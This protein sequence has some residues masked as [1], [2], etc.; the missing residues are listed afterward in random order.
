MN[1]MK[2]TFFMISIWSLSTCLEM[3]F[4]AEEHIKPVDVVVI[5]PTQ[6]IFTDK[7]PIQGNIIAKEFAILSARTPGALDNIFVDKGDSIK[8]GQILFETDKTNLENQV[9]AAEQNINVALASLEE[10]NATIEQCKANYQKT[11]RDFERFQSLYQSGVTTSDMKE[12]AELVFVQAKAMLKQAE[13]K[14]VLVEAKIQQA[15]TGLAICQKNRNDSQV[16]AAFNAVVS[17]RFREPGEF[18]GSGT[19]ILRLVNMDSLEISVALNAEYYGQIQVQKSKLLVE[20]GQTQAE[21]LV[22][23]RAPTVDPITRTFEIRAKIPHK[24]NKYELTEGMACNLQVILQTRQGWG[25]PSGAINIRSNQKVIYLNNQEVAQ[26][27]VVQTGII[28][29]GETEILF[30]KN[31]QN[32]EVIV[33]GQNFVNDKSALRVKRNP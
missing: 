20:I 25:V 19:P 33:E 30:P 8:K 4:A 31:L 7:L 15:K 29:G 32:T 17:E 13:A 24:I 10:V 1:I 18:V 12:K 14:K 9:L 27:V 21:F 23:Y 3:S 22:S 5:Q 26:K 6:R 16:K 28:D 2:K 11:K